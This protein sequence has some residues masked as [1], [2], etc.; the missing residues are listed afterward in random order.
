ME[1]K[2]LLL[3]LALLLASPLVHAEACD[4][5]AVSFMVAGVDKWEGLSMIEIHQRENKAKISGFAKGET[6]GLALKDLV[7]P[8]AQQGILNDWTF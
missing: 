8:Y 7:S 4:E 2:H 6:E 3:L 1:I 5:F